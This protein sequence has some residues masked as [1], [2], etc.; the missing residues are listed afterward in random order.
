MK[1]PFKGIAASSGI[2][3]G[4]AFMINEPTFQFTETKVLNIEAEQKKFDDALEVS[5]QEI[6][7][8]RE[9]VASE[10][11]DESAAIFDAH[12]LL[13]NDPDVIQSVQDR[14]STRLNSSHVS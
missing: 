10:Q 3:F 6:A 8:L 14:K 1:P 11:N 7:E 9:K 4:H 12:Q 2:A 13:L 5:L